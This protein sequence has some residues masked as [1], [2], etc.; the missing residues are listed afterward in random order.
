MPFELVLLRINHVR[1]NRSRPVFQISNFSQ[2][3]TSMF[4]K[5]K[6]E[7]ITGNLVQFQ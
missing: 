4:L 3:D 5:A 6:Y 1:I 2:K 7:I